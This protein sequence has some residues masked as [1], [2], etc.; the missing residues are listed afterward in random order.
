MVQKETIVG[1]YLWSLYSDIIYLQYNSLILTVQF[2]KFWEPEQY[3][4]NEKNVL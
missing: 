1:I 2:Y 3:R 4:E